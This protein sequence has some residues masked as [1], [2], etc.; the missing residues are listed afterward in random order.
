ML[1][2]SSTAVAWVHS[3]LEWVD[4]WQKIFHG[5]MWSLVE[6]LLNNFRIMFGWVL[7]LEFLLCKGLYMCEAI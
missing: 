1:T 5:L 4:H 7:V 6:L 3:A 2:L